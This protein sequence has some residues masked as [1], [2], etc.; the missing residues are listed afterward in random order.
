V[1]EILEMDELIAVLMLVGFLLFLF[2]Q[3]DREGTHFEP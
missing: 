2:Y 3:G 1:V